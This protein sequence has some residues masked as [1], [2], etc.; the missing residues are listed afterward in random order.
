MSFYEENRVLLVVLILSFTAVVAL[1]WYR[2]RPVRSAAMSG[3]SSR[4]GAARRQA[5]IRL[6]RSVVVDVVLLAATPLFV[7]ALLLTRL[8]FGQ[9]RWNTGGGIL[10]AL[11]TAGFSVYFG[12]RLWATL[13][14]RRA[15]KQSIDDLVAVGLELHRAT[16]DRWRIFTDFQAGRLALD[17]V[18]VGAAGVFAVQTISLVRPRRHSPMVAYDGRA[19]YFRSRSD[20]RILSQARLRAAELS[21]WIEKTVGETVAVRA[22]VILPGWQVKRTGHEGIPVIG[23]SQARSL[24][25]HIRPRPLAPPALQSIAQKIE[26]QCRRRRSR[27]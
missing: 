3:A 11:L 24:F 27:R 26:F 23:L 7:Y 6:E 21:R 2:S 20:T 8:H 25:R 14:K 17:F 1:Q 13:R 5:L 18:V 16:G 4:Q 22:V 9:G 15:L 12:H 19:L 10:L